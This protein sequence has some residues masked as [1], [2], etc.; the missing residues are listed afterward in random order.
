MTRVLVVD[1]ARHVRGMLVDMLTASGFAVVGA[2]ASGLSGL[3]LAT[4]LAPDAVVVDLEM[5]C[6]DGL[7]T[8]RRLR[9]R[10]PTVRLVLNADRLDDATRVRAAEAGADACVGKREGVHVL[11]RELLP[12]TLLEAAV[13]AA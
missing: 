6:M 13:G 7:E 8:V 11:E 3:I 1:D 2:A 9:S 12:F 10:F 5:P 4:E